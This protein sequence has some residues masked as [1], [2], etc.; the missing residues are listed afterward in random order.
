MVASPLPLGA[1]NDGALL[2]WWAQGFFDKHLWLLQYHIP[3]PSTVSLQP[4]AVLSLRQS[5]E[6]WV[7]SPSPYPHQQLHI[8]GWRNQVLARTLCAGLSP[9][10]PSQR[11]VV[12][13]S[14]PVI[15]LFCL[16]WSSHQ[17]GG[18]PGCK[19]FFFFSS[20]PGAQVSSCFHFHFF[21]I[22]PSSYIETFPVLSGMWG[23]LL[24]FY[25]CSVRIF[26]FEDVSLMY[27]WEEVS[28]LSCYSAILVGSPLWAVFKNQI[29]FQKTKIQFPPA[30]K[31][32][33]QRLDYP[34]TLSLRHL[35]LSVPYKREGR[36]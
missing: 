31:M 6:P 9:F 32:D 2:L 7:P 1:L 22:V 5:S 18:F 24:I 12:L 19:L 23:L 35:P 11:V 30:A 8:S 28:F 25:T 34:L 21:P 36:A 13:S 20:L 14:D 33:E 15:L 26:L 29:H 4:A 17:W 10:C 3:V 16:A 27:L